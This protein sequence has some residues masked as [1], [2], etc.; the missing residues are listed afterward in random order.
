MFRP[1]ATHTVVA[2]LREVDVSRTRP[3]GTSA[4]EPMKTDIRSEVFERKARHQPIFKHVTF[5]RIKASLC[6]ILLRVF[7]ITMDSECVSGVIQGILGGFL[8]FF[9]VSR[10]SF[11]FRLFTLTQNPLLFFLPKNNKL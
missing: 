8:F 5:M 10:K 6:I 3:N 4:S 2:Y 1:K 7:S 11:L 9:F